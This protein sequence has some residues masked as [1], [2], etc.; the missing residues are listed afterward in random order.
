MLTH[1]G[2][3][4]TLDEEKASWTGEGTDG[5]GGCWN[6]ENNSNCVDAI[7]MIISKPTD[8]GGTRRWED[9]VVKSAMRKVPVR[10]GK[11]EIFSKCISTWHLDVRQVFGLAGQPPDRE[12][13]YYFVT[14]CS[15]HSP[16]V[17]NP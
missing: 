14:I 9:I 12:N 1:Y 8:V 3:L 2:Y 6:W 7:N 13:Q 11:I 16:P 4:C 10:I 5:Q 17:E 15:R